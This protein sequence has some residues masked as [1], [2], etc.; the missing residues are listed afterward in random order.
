MA[1][2]DISLSVQRDARWWNNP[3]PPHPRPLC[4]SEHHLPSYLLLSAHLTKHHLSL[5]MTFCL[6]FVCLKR[7]LIYHVFLY[8]ISRLVIHFLVTNNYNTDIIYIHVFDCGIWYYLAP[9]WCKTKSSSHSLH[10]RTY[11]GG[12][13]NHLFSSKRKG[14][15]PSRWLYSLIQGSFTSKDACINYYNVLWK[16]TL[17]SS[18]AFAGAR[19]MQVVSSKLSHKKRKAVPHPHSKL[20]CVEK[21]RPPC[22]FVQIRL[23]RGPFSIAGLVNKTFCNHEGAFRK[24]NRSQFQKSLFKGHKSRWPKE[25]AIF[26]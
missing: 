14:K 6:I 12:M 4:I 9:R 23:L 17:C 13:S 20:Y 5:K 2:C 3:T 25:K 26:W 16:Q 8:F 7:G 18:P 22:V 15:D 19:E 1:E 21:E 24:R 10:S 11:C